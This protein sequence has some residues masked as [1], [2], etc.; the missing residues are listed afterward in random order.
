MKKKKLILDCDDVLADLIPTWLEAYNKDYNDAL[1]TEDIKSWDIME[2][3]KPEC[4]TNIFT[5]LDPTLDGKSLWNDMPPV[6]GAVEMV[7]LLKDRVDIFI[8]SSVMNNYSNCIHKHNW[9]VKHFP[10]LDPK[11]FYFVTDKS[12][13]AGSHMLDDRHTNM[14]HFPGV[15][16][17]FSRPHNKKIITSSSK[18]GLQRVENWEQAYKKI[19]DGT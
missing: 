8:V 10:Y 16:L 7:G 11:K 14:T 5:Y 19:V 6:E 9:L 15:K 1:T 12:A 4:G 2:Y 13:I 3:V 17:L 18:G